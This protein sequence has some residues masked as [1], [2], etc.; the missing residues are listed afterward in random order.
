MFRSNFRAGLN[1]RRDV[2]VTAKVRRRS[3]RASR[4]AR[5]YRDVKSS[6]EPVRRYDGVVEGEFRFNRPFRSIPSYVSVHSTARSVNRWCGMGEERG[7][8]PLLEH[9]ERRGRTRWFWNR[10]LIG[11][12]NLRKPFARLDGPT[13]NS[14]RGQHFGVWSCGDHKKSA[15]YTLDAVQY[16]SSVR[17]FPK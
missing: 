4:T 14:T 10:A 11:G 1:H 15:T 16:K 12:G 7:P 13:T 2:P 17:R 6:N 9:V 8:S 5:G 3:R